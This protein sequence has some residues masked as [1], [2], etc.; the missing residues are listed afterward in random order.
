MNLYQLSRQTLIIVN[1]VFALASLGVIGVGTY[2]YIESNSITDDAELLESLPVKKICIGIITAGAVLF[3]FALIGL[4]GTLYKIKLALFLYV[5]VLFVLFAGQ[6]TAA[7]I[8]VTE[9]GNSKLDNLFEDQW[10]ESSNNAEVAAY[11][12]QF[13]CCGWPGVGNVTGRPVC[14]AT[15]EDCRAATIDWFKS[16]LLPVGIV[17]IIITGLEF[18]GLVA[19][20]Y[21]VCVMNK[22]ENFYS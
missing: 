18:L 6:I 12:N 17:V 22:R 20:I 19:G 14:N 7:I 5:L 4:A 2:G 21:F 8:L 15:L 3:V 10:A 11:Q 1:I 9:N 13:D 16:K